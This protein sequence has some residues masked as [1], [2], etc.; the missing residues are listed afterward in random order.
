MTAPAVSV[1]GLGPMGHP[2]AARLVDSDMATAVWNRTQGRADDLVDRGALRA[3]DLAAA[4]APVILSVLPDVAPLRDLLT[5]EV[6]SAWGAAGA[7]L[8]ILSTTGPDQVRDLARDLAGDG[9]VVLDAPVSGG[10]RG[11]ED[12]SLA[13]MVGGSTP[14]VEAV[15]PVLEV[16]GGSVVHVGD[17]GAGCVA[18][19]CNQIIVAGTLASITE[20]L[21]LA[22][23]SGIDLDQLLQILEGGLARSEV[24]SQK[25]GKLRD[26]EYSLGGSAVNQVKDLRYA[27]QAAQGAG[28]PAQLLPTLLDL[29]EQACTLRDG[30]AAQLDH[31]VVQE[32]YIDPI[33]ARDIEA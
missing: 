32:L 25:S 29:F 5:A 2:I 30:E 9:V 20:A 15:R 17:L 3:E 13:I 19:L 10:V 26:R 6:R 4:A 14:D 11:A 8:L 33:E 27:T 28:L 16:I 31:T 21:G 24:L 18:K 12:G 22:R 7:R 1:I 23:R